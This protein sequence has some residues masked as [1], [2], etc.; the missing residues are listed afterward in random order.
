MWGRCN[1]TGRQGS[2]LLRGE[3]GGRADLENRRCGSVM[4]IFFVNSCTL[5]VVFVRSMQPTLY[6]L[7]LQLYIPWYSQ[8]RVIGNL[9][10]RILTAPRA[11]AV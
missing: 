11:S 5:D 8:Y 10:L 3:A 4:H 6:R 2:K 7:L 1:D 9:R